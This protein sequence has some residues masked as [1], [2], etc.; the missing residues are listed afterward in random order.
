MRRELTLQTRI[1]LGRCRTLD[2]ALAVLAYSETDNKR[3]VGAQAIWDLKGRLEKVQQPEE[4][5]ELEEMRSGRKMNP[6]CCYGLFMP[7]PRIRLS[8]EI[9]AH[10]KAGIR[11]SLDG[12]DPVWDA[13][14][15]T[16]Y[17]RFVEEHLPVVEIRDPQEVS[18]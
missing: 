14:Y 2:E 1:E 9:V 11:K 8:A 4:D 7:E 15:R 13:A 17:D 18:E 5:A 16:A 3:Y 6:T 10:E 12:K